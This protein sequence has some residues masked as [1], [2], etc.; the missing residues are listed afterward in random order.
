MGPCF[1]Q[2]ASFICLCSLF[3]MGAAA[4]GPEARASP[5]FA[6]QDRAASPAPTLGRGLRLG[7]RC[8]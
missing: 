8:T 2:L 1:E 5:A 4:A 3:S 6:S 7:L